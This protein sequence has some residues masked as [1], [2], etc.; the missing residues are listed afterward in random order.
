LIVSKA[1]HFS[2][3]P[4]CPGRAKLDMC[5]V[6]QKKSDSLTDAS[7][8]QSKLQKFIFMSS[9]PEAEIKILKA[10]QPA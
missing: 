6:E 9:Q 7:R 4:V 1:F 3:Q 2:R 10:R 8:T 5:I